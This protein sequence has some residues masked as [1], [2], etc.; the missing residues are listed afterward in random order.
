[1]PIIKPPRFQPSPILYSAIA[2]AV[3]IVI[4]GSIVAV[5]QSGISGRQ[6]FSQINQTLT[7][8][9]GWN[10]VVKVDR[11]TLPADGQS[12]AVITVT[13]T[14]SRQTV[15]ASLIQGDGNIARTPSA[16]QPYIFTYT[17]GTTTGKTLIL[18]KSGSI[19]QTVTITLAE[20][21]IPATPVLTSPPDG[22]A[23]DTPKPEVVGTGLPNIKIIITNNGTVNTT[24]H[25]DANGQFR[26]HLDEPLY[27]GQHTLSAVAVS[28]LGISSPVSNLVT[29]TV[30]TAP[31][32]LD[33]ANIR[34]VP[35]RPIAGESFGLF[36][37]SSLNTA[38]VVAELEGRSF[39]LFDH[40]DSSIFTGTLPAPEQPG[41]YSISLTATDLAGNTSRFDRL[42]RLTVVSA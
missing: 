25:T 33:T 4:V 1:M 13:P 2:L 22:V 32:K 36:V 20:A 8:V 21:T 17:A 30:Q 26:V 39:E 31:V 14:R 10:L 35:S 27:N 24:T 16:D 29:I 38:K 9:L 34:L 28:D 23:I 42:I 41:T 37:P 15:T 40:N 12:Q 3:V 18:I 19:E 7:R 6:V 5:A 11:D